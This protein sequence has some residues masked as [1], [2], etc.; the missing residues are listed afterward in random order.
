MNQ[1]FFEISFALPHFLL[2]W[3]TLS[4]IAASPGPS[5]MAIMGISM[6]QGC[7]AG[8][9]VWLT[10]YANSLILLKII[11]GFYLLWMAFKSFRSAMT[12]DA[13]IATMA[14]TPKAK[15]FI[16]SHF[17]LLFPVSG[18]EEAA[19]VREDVDAIAEQGQV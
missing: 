6:P 2:A 17:Q 14:S 9:S 10:S 5:A 7:S 13:D 12:A 18:G 3:A 4:L 16:Q 1:A 11:D 15:Q 19:D 8:L